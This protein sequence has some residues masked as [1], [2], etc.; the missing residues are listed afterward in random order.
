MHNKKIKRAFFAAFPKTLPVFAGYLFLGMTYGIYLASCGLPA[1]FPVIMTISIF[2]GVGE[3]L[4][5]GLLASSFNPLNALAIAMITGARYLFYGIS[6]LEKYKNVGWKK[7]FLIYETVDETFSINFQSVLQPDV[8]PG[9][10]YLFVTWLDHAYWIFG[11]LVGAF[12]GSMIGFNARGLDFVVTAMFVVIFLDQCA[13][14]K[15]HWSEL[16]GVGASVVCLVLFGAD[17]FIVPTMV[18]ILAVLAFFR[19]PL[20]KVA[21]EN[22]QYKIA[23]ARKLEEEALK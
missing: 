10:Y 11:S 7:F 19:K 15:R 17:I 14:E 1:W 6:M 2:S 20:E 3:I 22:E 4:A 18:V 23:R 16:L 21:E 5:V 13:T 9:W 12:F 8:D